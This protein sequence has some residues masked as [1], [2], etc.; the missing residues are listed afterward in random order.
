MPKLNGCLAAHHPWKVHTWDLSAQ[1][2]ISLWEERR[3]NTSL[4]WIIS[5]E[6]LLMVFK[7][8]A[9]KRITCVLTV[10]IRLSKLGHRRRCF[11]GNASESWG[12]AHSMSKR[13]LFPRSSH[14][15]VVSP[16][17]ITQ[18]HCLF[19]FSSAGQQVQGPSFAI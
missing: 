1:E 2:K 15:D 3:E 4:Q 16:S 12:L 11:L 7:Q 13:R 6:F 9:S 5:S 18:S 17:D 14:A 19:F 10:L 8:V